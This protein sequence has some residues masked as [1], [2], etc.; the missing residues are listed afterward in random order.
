MVVKATGVIVVMIERGLFMKCDYPCKIYSLFGRL[1]ADI[2]VED[3]VL[4]W[5]HE[6]TEVFLDDKFDLH[7]CFISLSKV[8]QYLT[9]KS[10]MLPQHQYVIAV[11]HLLSP[12][13]YNGL[14]SW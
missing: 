14:L 12:Y 13:G 9:N 1:V 10:N 4:G 8:E 5:V 7:N 6:V 11:S 2:D 3:D